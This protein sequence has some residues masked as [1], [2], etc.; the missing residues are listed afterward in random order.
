MRDSTAALRALAERI[1]GARLGRLLTTSAAFRM[2]E[3]LAVELSL[4]GNDGTLSLLVASTGRG[5][6]RTTAALILA[7]HA[8]WSDP[9]R[10]VLLVDADFGQVNARRGLS[11]LMGIEAGQAGLRDTLYGDGALAG[12]VVPTA[13]PNLSVL[14]LGRAIRRGVRA[15]PGRLEQAMRELRTMADFIV[16][17]PIACSDGREVLVLARATQTVLMVGR[18]GGPTS[19]EVVGNVHEFGRGGANVLGCIL[20]QYRPLLPW[21]FRSGTERALS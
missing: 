14:P 20:S 17:D 19:D 8:A 15:P 16:V 7:V 1:G 18:Q 2:S 9:E 3:A 10:R 6:G 21:P 5:E 12:L 4:M 13:F 11:G